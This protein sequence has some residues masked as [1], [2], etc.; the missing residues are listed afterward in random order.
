MS[1]TRFLS[2]NFSQQAR[3]SSTDERH[4][5]ATFDARFSLRIWKSRRP[6]FSYRF[7]AR[8][9][10]HFYEF[11]SL[12]NACTRHRSL[13]FKSDSGPGDT[14]IGLLDLRSFRS[15][16]SWFRVHTTTFPK[17]SWILMAAVTLRRSNYRSGL[18]CSRYTSFRQC[19][20]ISCMSISIS[21]DDIR[22]R[23]FFFVEDSAQSSS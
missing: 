10:S 15:I 9:C 13:H 16:D 19:L 2:F 17:R 8:K 23:S 11:L 22:A 7:S 14:V 1:L 20:W 3:I 4:F 5:R 6:R 21:A 12:R 18:K